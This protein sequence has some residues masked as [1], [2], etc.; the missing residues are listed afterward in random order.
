VNAPGI[1]V[2][3]IRLACRGQPRQAHEKDAEREAAQTEHELAEIPVGGHE[4]ALL[5]VGQVEHGVVGDARSQFGYVDDVV[6]VG[7]E[8]AD[9]G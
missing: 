9:D 2:P 4:D 1:S 7:P 6:A 3:C 8:P 5:G